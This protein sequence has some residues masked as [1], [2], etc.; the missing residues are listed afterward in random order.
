LFLYIIFCAKSFA[1]GWIA[2]WIFF[3]AVVGFIAKDKTMGFWGGFLIALILSPLIGF[4]IVLVSRDR[5]T[6]ITETRT[7]HNPSPVQEQKVTQQSIADEIEK[8]KKQLD[9]GA[10]TQEEYQ[11]LKNKIIAK[12]D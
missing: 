5:V 12:F 10:I 7:V 3:A 1:M 8:L 11:M 2:I 9:S 4:I 6:Y